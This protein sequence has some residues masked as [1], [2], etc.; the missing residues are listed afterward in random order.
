MSNVNA[1]PYIW[2]GKKVVL[3][4]NKIK[5]QLLKLIPCISISMKVLESSTLKF[6]I[7]YLNFFIFVW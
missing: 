6:V 7:M 3:T 2:F 4:I 1:L 5:V